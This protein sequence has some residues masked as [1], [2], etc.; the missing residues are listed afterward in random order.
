[1]QRGGSAEANEFDDD[2]QQ[3]APSRRATD[4]CGAA[5]DNQVLEQAFTAV[6][7]CT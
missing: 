1:M 7:R 2:D 6:T 4:E 5:H 3:I